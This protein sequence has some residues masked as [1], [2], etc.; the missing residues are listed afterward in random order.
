MNLILVVALG[1]TFLLAFSIGLNLG[2]H[3]ILSVGDKILIRTKIGTVDHIAVSKGNEAAKTVVADIDGVSEGK[4][5]PNNDAIEEQSLDSRKQ[6]GASTPS[7]LRILHEIYEAKSVR[8]AMTAASIESNK[9]AIATY[10]EGGGK[11]PI[12]L[13]TCNRPDQLRETL[14]SLLA[15]RGVSKENLLIAQDGAMQQIADVVYEFGL[16]LLQNKEGLRL[17]GGVGGD[18]AQRIAKH[19]KY[20]LSAAF[21]R[22]PSAPAIIITEDDLLFSPDFYE[23]LVST[24]PIL[25]KDP[26]T[27]VVSAWNDNGFKDKVNDASMIKRTEF[28]PGLG[29]LLPRE[30]YKN[31][32]EA[33]WPTEHWD[34]WLRSVEVHGT[35]DIVY[36]EV[37]TCIYAIFVLTFVNRIVYLYL[38]I[39]FFFNLLIYLFIYSFIHLFILFFILYLLSP[40]SSESLCL[41]LLSFAFPFKVPRTFHNGIVGTFMNLETHN[42]YFRDVAYN[43]NEKVKWNVQT[44]ITESGDSSTLLVIPNYLKGIFVNVLS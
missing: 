11:I 13:L 33:K 32:L 1:V 23:Y 25:E 34:H 5:G 3:G 8:D 26:T 4:K 40:F 2:L 35:R 6:T 19:Y 12:V 16:D 28:F 43:T 37:R 22:A 36:P 44:G 41:R 38:F 20:S 30:L 18:G 14:T 42:R 27:F 29:W 24:A 7:A 9:G 17:R 10:L 21:D 15:V 31:E 39:S